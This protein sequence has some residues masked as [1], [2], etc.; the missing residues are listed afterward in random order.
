LNQFYGPLH[1]V[2]LYPEGSASWNFNSKNIST[3][4]K[5]GSRVSAKDYYSF[6]LMVRPN[7]VNLL[8]HLFGK[9]FHQYIV[10]MYAKMD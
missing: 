8:V 9:L 6:H 1:Y 3:P 4:E 5:E 7:N 10:D 2:L